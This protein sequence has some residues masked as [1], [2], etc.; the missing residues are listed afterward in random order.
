[1]NFKRKVIKLNSSIALSLALLSCV[2]VETNS[3]HTVQASSYQ[4]AKLTHNAFIYDSKGRRKIGFTLK[5]GKL[6]KVYD[7]KK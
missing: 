4:K 1:M 2:E 5:K 7:R 3:L 6:I